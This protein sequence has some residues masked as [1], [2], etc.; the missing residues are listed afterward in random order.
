MGGLEDGRSADEEVDS[1][2]KRTVL[3]FVFAVICAVAA[4]GQGFLNLDF[5][6]AYD[7]PGNPPFPD[8]VFVSATSALPGWIPYN[9]SVALSEI[10]YV[11]NFFGGASTPV[12]LEGGSLALS[13]NFGV[14]LYL[15]ASIDQTGIVPGNAESLQFEAASLLGLDVTLGGQNLSYLVLSQGSGY[16]VYG[17]KIPADLDGQTEALT[18]SI[19]AVGG[20]ALLDNIEFSPMSVPEPTEFTFIGLGAI[21]FGL[22]RCRSGR[23][24]RWVVR[25]YRG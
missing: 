12:E 1:V 11:S 16:T 23:A 25:G 19:L 5:E 4:K 2:M 18:F 15:G 24:R 13:G 17:A 6:S 9:G 7:L 20:S 21:L 10:N 8:G 22:V 14:G 3:S